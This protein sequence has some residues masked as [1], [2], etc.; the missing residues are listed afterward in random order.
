MA[1]VIILLLPEAL[2]YWTGL[3]KKMEWDDFVHLSD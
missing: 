1:I 2:R 3:G